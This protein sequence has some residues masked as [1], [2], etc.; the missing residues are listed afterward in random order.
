MMYVVSECYLHIYLAL[1]VV[2]ECFLEQFLMLSVVMTDD[3]HSIAY[4]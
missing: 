4:P 1:I 2:F 3:V